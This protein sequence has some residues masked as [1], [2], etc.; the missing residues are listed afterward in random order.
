MGAT[1]AFH[2]RLADVPQRVLANPALL[3][4]VPLGK[5]RRRVLRSSSRRLDRFAK[6][7]RNV[8]IGLLGLAKRLHRLSPLRWGQPTDPAQPILKFRALHQ[9]LLESDAPRIA[10]NQY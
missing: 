10:R 7:R 1:P 3:A 9:R 4:R 8:L 5:R 6:A 2:L